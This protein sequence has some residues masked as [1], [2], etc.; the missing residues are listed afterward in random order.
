MGIRRNNMD[1]Y[2]KLREILDTHPVGAPKSVVFDKIL[3]ML[4]KPEEAAVLTHMTFS[5]KPVD[6]IAAA[7]GVPVEEADRML[8]D[9]ADR[10]L[11]FSREKG[12]MRSYGLLSVMPGLFEYPFMRGK[13][14]PELENLG[15]LWDEY[16]SDGRGAAFAGNPTPLIR[17][18]PVEKSLDASHRVYPYE[19]VKNII[20]GVDF[21]G[22][23]QCACRVSLHRCDKPTETCLF[24]DAPAQFLVEKK[25]ARQIT[26]EEALD[27]LRRAEEAGL[28]HMSTNS[29]DRAGVICNCCRCCCVFLTGRTQL[30]LASTFAPSGFL[31]EVKAK[32]CTGCGICA[33]EL[34]PVGAIEMKEEV[35]FVTTEKCI[36]C[37]LCVTACPIEAIALV[38]RSDAPEIPAT[39]QEMLGKVLT[40][41]GKLA[42]FKKL[43]QS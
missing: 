27:V 31:A 7:A 43:M 5:S 25:Y 23:G 34:C 8:G 3:R 40:E 6:A 32:E 21:I 29:A 19:D 15:K 33:D 28:I 36:G 42:E 35:A 17:V 9:L 24:F 26:R 13:M 14:T 11:V 1:V 10:V 41:K 37:G 20:D 39:N 16:Q 4:F 12:G 18:V 38:R 2:E 30:D 22:L